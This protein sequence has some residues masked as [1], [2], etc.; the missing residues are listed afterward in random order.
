MAALYCAVSEAAYMSIPF[1]KVQGAGNDFVLVDARGP[2]AER[3]RLD[4]GAAAPKICDRHF[5]IGADGIL[6]VEDTEAAAAR[7]AIVNADGSDGQMCGNGFRCFTKYLIE[8]AG[9]RPTGGRLPIETGAGVL[10]AE[11]DGAADPITQVRVAVGPAYLEPEQV[12]VRAPAPGPVLRHRVQAAGRELELTCVGMGNPHAVWF[13]DEE[14]DNFPLA[15][16]GPLIEHHP[17]F[18]S[19]VN[20]E[21]VNVLAPD[22][23]RMRVWERGVGETLACGSG[24]C[25]VL[26]AACLRGLAGQRAAVEPPG[27]AL[28]IAWDGRNQPNASVYMTGPAEFTFEGAIPSDWF[29]NGHA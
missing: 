25:A 6:L 9:L 11:L 22:R 26:V 28:E 3:R 21:I 23:L 12:P 29:A 14:I 10:H 2:L 15:E 20:F 8:R 13:T 16:I 7:M 17:D 24:A 19:R 27:G 5:G 1:L 18:P 4:W